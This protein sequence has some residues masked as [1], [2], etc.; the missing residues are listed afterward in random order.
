LI[1]IRL[2]PQAELPDY[3]PTLGDLYAAVGT[4]LELSIDVLDEGAVG[5]VISTAEAAGGGEALDRL[6][7]TFFGVD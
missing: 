1:P 3:M 2:L 7:L 6:W 4:G 5:A